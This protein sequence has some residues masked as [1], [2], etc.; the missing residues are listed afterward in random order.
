MDELLIL[1]AANRI[2][3]GFVIVIARL[4]VYQRHYN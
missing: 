3:N 2:L 4:F 1:L